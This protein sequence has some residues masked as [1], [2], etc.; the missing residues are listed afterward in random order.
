MKRHIFAASLLVITSSTVSAAVSLYQGGG[1]HTDTIDEARNTFVAA[2]SATVEDFETGFASSNSIDFPIGGPTEFTATSPKTLFQGRYD[3]VSGM[4]N[5]YNKGGNTGHSVTFSFVSPTT[6]FGIDIRDVAD[7][8]N[9][10]NFS[11]ST[12][13][14]GT[15]TTLYNT[16]HNEFF[17][18][19]STTPFTSITF[20]WTD[21]GDTVFWDDLRHETT[22]IAGGAPTTVPVMSG[23][24]LLMLTVSLV[25]LGLGALRR[26]R[27]G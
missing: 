8:D 23:P 14:S 27:Q 26:F 25:G 18:I 15:A 13:D 24:L 22:V 7:N 20:T 19:T 1:D 16:Y 3:P 12:G 6:A 21:G 17:G 5:L 9:I 2:T 10:L 11:L 4:S